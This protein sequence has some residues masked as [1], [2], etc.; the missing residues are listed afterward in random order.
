MTPTDPQREGGTAS[1]AAEQV[2][3]AHPLGRRS[4]ILRLAGIYGPGRV[5]FIEDLR[6]ERPIVAPDAGYL[7]LIHV[8][9]VVSVVLAAM[10]FAPFNDGPHLYCVSDGHPVQRAE[11]YREVARQIGAPPPRFV[12]PDASS[13]RAERARGNRRIRNDKMLAE[14]KVMFSYP[15]YRAGL[16]AILDT[17]NQ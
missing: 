4:V 2:L 5:P 14:L 10:R 9:D 3:A 17:E 12:E 15:D 13:P 7:N 1:L 11:F 6:S 8:D 16:K